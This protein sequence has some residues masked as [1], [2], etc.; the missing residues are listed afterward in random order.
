MWYKRIL[1]KCYIPTPNEKVL[2]KYFIPLFFLVRD[3]LSLISTEGC[4][5]K[6][7]KSLIPSMERKWIPISSLWGPCFTGMDTLTT[8]ILLPFW[9]LESVKQH[10]NPLHFQILCWEV[11]ICEHQGGVCQ[12]HV[13][14]AYIC[15]KIIKWMELNTEIGRTPNI[16]YVKKP[17]QLF[18]PKK[19]GYSRLVYIKYFF[20][21]AHFVP[22]SFLLT[23]KSSSNTNPFTK[24]NFKSLHCC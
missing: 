6:E 12:M 1:K 23:R 16:K 17:C 20:I 10:K 24:T 18:I 19:R 5:A 22:S 7:K 9:F 3:H 4:L 2:I 13:R 14:N 8:N 15:K 11:G 21:L